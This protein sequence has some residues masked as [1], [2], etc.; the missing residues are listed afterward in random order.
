MNF[1]I[2]VQVLNFYY[3]FYLY[4]FLLYKNTENGEI[5]KINWISKNFYYKNEI[6]LSLKFEDFSKMASEPIIPQNEIGPFYI[7]L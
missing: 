3:V 4:L 5:S 7:Y 2:T 6:I 1:C